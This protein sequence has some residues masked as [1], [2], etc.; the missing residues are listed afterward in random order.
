MHDLG[1]SPLHRLAAIRTF[2]DIAGHR[3]AEPLADLPEIVGELLFADH[4]VCVCIQ[5]KEHFAYGVLG[6]GLLFEHSLEGGICDEEPPSGRLG[7][8]AARHLAPD[9][10]TV[11]VIQSLDVLQAVVALG[12]RI[13]LLCATDDFRWGADGRRTRRNRPEHDGAAAQLRAVANTDVPKHRNVSAQQYVLPDLR[14]AVAPDLARRTE[15]HAVQHRTPLAQV[16]RLA[17][18]DARCVV[19]DDRRPNRRRGV[20]VDAKRR[21][22]AALEPQRERP[23]AAE[24]RAVRDAV[25]DE[26]GEALEI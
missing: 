13:R 24:P 6:H 1:H 22:R 10:G 20:D 21:R 4:T 7:H 5:S 25:G 23:L 12:S 26:R 2:E 14:M 18:D 16:R 9:A 19:H 8:A 3:P 11:G 17:D 15:R